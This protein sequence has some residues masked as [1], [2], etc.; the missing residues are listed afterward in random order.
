MP[1]IGIGQGAFAAVIKTEKHGGVLFRGSALEELMIQQR[2]QSRGG[3]FDSLDGE[4][5]TIL[6]PA[7]AAA[8]DSR[9][10]GIPSKV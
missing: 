3:N 6:V 1:G 2:Q 4:R 8:S 10:M 9:K 7:I 5:Q